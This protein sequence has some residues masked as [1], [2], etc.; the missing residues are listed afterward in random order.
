MKTYRNLWPALCSFENL[1][2]AWRKARR[3]K[4][5]KRQVIQFEADLEDN[6][7]TLLDELESGAY[8][9][10]R[11]TNFYVYEPKKRKISAAP[12]RDRVVHHALCNVLEPIFER[13]FIHDSY[14]CRVGKGTHR[15]LDRCTHFARR[16]PYVLKCD[17]ARFFPTVDHQILL[18]I[19]GRT[20]AD[21][22]TMALVSVILENGLGILDEEAPTAWFPGDDLLGPL[23]PK[24]LPIGNLTSQFWANV[25][26]NELD[27]HV[28]R[29]LEVRG[30]LRYTDDFL[31]FGQSKAQLW[32]WRHQVISFLASLRLSPNGRSFR[33]F[34]V[35]QGIEFLGFRVYPD[36]R[37][38]LAANVRRS[39]LRLR[40]LSRLFAQR[41][42][43]VER[44]SASVLAWVAHA[45]HADTRGL[46]RSVLREF[47]GKRAAHARIPDLHQDR[48]EESYRSTPGLCGL[49]RGRRQNS[50]APCG[51]RGTRSR[52]R[53]LGQ[54]NQFLSQ[55]SG[56]N[57]GNRIG[58]RHGV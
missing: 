10:G 14:A 2:L 38:L 5:T 26:L 37:R 12:F 34:P 33:V 1:Y 6:L 39:R 48:R 44:V 52:S 9:P 45:S 16:F 3:G 29:V 54:G 11:H 32:E 42:I 49:P 8:Q 23:R 22:R 20:I 35:T 15:A 51:K 58:G 43:P 47:V 40:R 41:R 31:L 17:V 50:P 56:R 36:H 25:L 24:G 7:F 4:S 21:A 30:Y 53:S 19:L 57:S 28:K 55:R 18:E 13:K 46:R 27:Q